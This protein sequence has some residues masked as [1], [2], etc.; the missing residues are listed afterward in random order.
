MLAPLNCSRNDETVA[1]QLIRTS[2][3]V[4]TAAA[5]NQYVRHDCLES[6]EKVPSYKYSKRTVVFVGNTPP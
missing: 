3:R 6:M 2:S 1:L 4:P 5:A